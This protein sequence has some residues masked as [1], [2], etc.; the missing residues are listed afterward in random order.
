MGIPLPMIDKQG[1]GR[2]REGSYDSTLRRMDPA[3]QCSLYYL[4]MCKKVGPPSSGQDWNRAQLT[5]SEDVNVEE[6]EK[7]AEIAHTTNGRPKKECL[8]SA[9][10]WQRTE[11]MGK[12]SSCIGA[13][14]DRREERRKCWCL[15]SAKDSVEEL[16]DKTEIKADEEDQAPAQDFVPERAGRPG[17]QDVRHKKQSPRSS[18]SGEEETL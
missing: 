16:L 11:G 2:R 15:W 9:K 5:I 6:L 14:E 17:Q 1:S 10:T 4:T 7:M 8:R 18:S 13:Q 3:A 12:A